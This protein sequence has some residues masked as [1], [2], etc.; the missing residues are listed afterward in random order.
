[1]PTASIRSRKLSSPPPVPGIRKDSQLRDATLSEHASE[2][3][4][5]RFAQQAVCFRGGAH[6]KA[7]VPQSQ[8]LA[9]LAQE[10]HEN[11]WVFDCLKRTSVDAL[12]RLLRQ[13]TR[14]SVLVQQG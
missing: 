7:Y 8:G 9:E 5:A 13:A 10:L 11:L 4:G 12:R 2:V 1:M 3:F 14:F 6:R